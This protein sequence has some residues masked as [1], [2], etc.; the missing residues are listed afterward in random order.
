MMEHISLRL[1][2]FYFIPF[3]LLLITLHHLYWAISSLL[4]LLQVRCIVEPLKWTFHFSYCTFQVKN[5]HVAL[6][7]NFCVFTYILYL[8]R[9]CQFFC[10]RG[11]LGSVNI[12]VVD[13]LVPL[14]RLTPGSS[15]KQFLLPFFPSVCITHPC[16]FACLIILY[17]KL[18]ILDNLPW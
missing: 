15:L 8:A 10:K 1:S 12:F 7:S 17:W 11:S 3:S 14:L 16:L 5:F 18:D 6:F 9:Q 13:A 2:S 4:I